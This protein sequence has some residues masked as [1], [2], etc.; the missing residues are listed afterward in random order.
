VV[1]EP[2][3][4]ARHAAFENGTADLGV[5]SL[6]SGFAQ[7]GK[8]AMPRPEAHL[9]LDEL[10]VLRHSGGEPSMERL[11]PYTHRTTQLGIPHGVERCSEHMNHGWTHRY[12]GEQ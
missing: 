11:A 5:A 2:S 3:A 12:S 1:P 7:M 6:P 9:L 10:V 8:V 4:D